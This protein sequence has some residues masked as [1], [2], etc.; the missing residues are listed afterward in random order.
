MTFICTAIFVFWQASSRDR[1]PAAS[2][3]VE[4]VIVSNHAETA[5][6]HRY[7]YGGIGGGELVFQLA[8]VFN[9]NG[10]VYRGTD[11]TLTLPSSNKVAVLYNPDDPSQNKIPKTEPR[12]IIGWILLGLGIL[13][14]VLFSG[15]TTRSTSK[16]REPEQ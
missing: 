15:M 7:R 9:I 3:P 12:K 10:R 16:D 14:I 2:Q 4:A 5:P 13:F 8:Y 1:F 6:Y 11:T